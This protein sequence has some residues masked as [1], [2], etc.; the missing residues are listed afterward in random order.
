MQTA[1]KQAITDASLLDKDGYDSASKL[2]NAIFYN[3]T[4]KQAIAFAPLSDKDGYASID[5]AG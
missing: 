1:T 4:T 5:Y 2:E 3:T